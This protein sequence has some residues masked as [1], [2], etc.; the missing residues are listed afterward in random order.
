MT[1]QSLLLAREFIQGSRSRGWGLYADRFREISDPIESTCQQVLYGQAR[2]EQQL[3]AIPRHRYELT[4]YEQFCNAPQHLVAQ[5]LALVPNLSA[6]PS[7]NL[8]T[9]Q[10]LRA[11]AK[12]CLSESDLVRVRRFFQVNATMADVRL[13]SAQGLSKPT[14]ASSNPAIEK[15]D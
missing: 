11:S 10:P 12:T 6:R 14:I 8:E 4:N 5:C 2:L 7:E 9:I 15:K 1:V 3:E 13:D